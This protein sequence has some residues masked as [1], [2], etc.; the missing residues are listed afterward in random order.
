MVSIAVNNV[1][2][3]STT[4]VQQAPSP[5]VTPSTDKP[6]V[7]EQTDVVNTQ[8][9]DAVQVRQAV[10]AIA[11]TIQSLSSNLEIS[12]DEDSGRSI[13]KVIDKETHELIRQMPS[14]EV[15][16]IAK[17]LDKFQGLLIQ[18]QA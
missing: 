4:A 7:R 2:P 5:P 9:A 17:A 18:Q 14:E 16:A 11:K 12:V 15:L 3:A 8:H 1:V 6:V 10:E 13:V